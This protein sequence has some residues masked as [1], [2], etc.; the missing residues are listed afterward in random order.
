M[1]ALGRAFLCGLVVVAAGCGSKGAQSH[2]AASDVPREAMAGDAPAAEVIAEVAP[3]VAAIE[4]APEAGVQ[5]PAE[6]GV[7]T[8]AEDGTD[9]PPEAGTD[10]PAEVGTDAPPTPRRYH[11]IAIALGSVHS[12]ALLDD[13]RVKCWGSGDS[14]ALGLGDMRSR[15]TVASEMGNA[16]PT[17]DLGTGRTAKQLAAGRYA[18]CALLDDDSVKCWGI[19]LLSGQANFS[20]NIGDEPNEMGD[21]LLPLP[22]GAGRK[23][24]AIGMSYYTACFARDDRTLHCWDTS[25][26]KGDVVTPD[27]TSV[28]RMFN[29]RSPL[30]LFDDGSLREISSTG[31]ALLV[32]AQTKALAAGGT[33]AGGCALLV[34]GGFDCWGNANANTVPA[35]MSGGRAL[36]YGEFQQTCGLT[37]GGEVRCWGSRVAGS[38]AAGGSLVMAIGAP[39]AALANGNGHFCA[40]TTAGDVKC[41]DFD[42]P[43]ASWVGGAV[44]TSTQWDAVDLGDRP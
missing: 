19:G 16:L 17:V 14:G 25:A 42:V 9:A 7:D 21:H 41:W 33:S 30:G 20:N 27:G 22:V 44:H 4:V 2:D 5:A 23:A 26:M 38:T 35:Q 11:A 6:A 8:L 10:A 24:V 18:T 34:P 15:G 3:E 1:R 29:G 28:V 32:G 12:C 31:I 40:L 13:H 43:F 36:A 37:A 39:V